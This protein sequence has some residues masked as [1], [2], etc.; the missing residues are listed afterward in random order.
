MKKVIYLIVL[1]FM[2]SCQSSISAGEVSLG[3]DFEMEFGQ[4]LTIPQESV[5][6]QF[7]DVLEDSRC[8][9]GA[10]CIWAG[11]AKIAILLN[12][13]EANLNT[14]LEPKQSRMSRYTVDLISVKPYPKVGVEVKKEDYVAKLRITKD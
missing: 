8:P 12:E 2:L 6:I 11:N 13:T 14:Y 10:T 5:R 7:K 4:N 3:E 9:E 1:S